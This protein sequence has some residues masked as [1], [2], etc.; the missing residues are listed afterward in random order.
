MEKKIKY[1][2]VE[3]EDKSRELLLR[4]IQ[5]CNISG[6]TC[7]GMAANATEAL[8]LSKMTPPD[9]ILL[10]INLPG[11]SGFELI[12]ELEK[13]GISPG[14]I[15]TSAHTEKEILLNALKHSP[16]TYLVKPID[17]DELEQ[18]IRKV[19]SLMQPAPSDHEI[20]GKIT[21][22]GNLG[23]VFLFPEHLL[24]IRAEGHY[25][26]ITVE[27]GKEIFVNQSIS[28]IEKINLLPFHKMFIRPDRST[29]LNLSKIVSIHTKS[30]ECILGSGS[31]LVS[32]KVSA[33]GVKIVMKMMSKL[34]RV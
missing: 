13:L 6:I 34:P 28:E 22:Q 20:Q 5:M 24:M 3:D 15:F 4:K 27:N 12:N 32:V 17:L 9:F 31:E 14:I 7:I 8:L 16:V 19:C 10:D 18:A 29:I 30:N 33:N 21:F 23:P 25:S 26:R 1:L 11:K 2:I